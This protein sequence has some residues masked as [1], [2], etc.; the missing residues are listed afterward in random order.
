MQEDILRAVLEVARHEGFE[1]MTMS[2]IAEEAGVAKGTLYLHFQ[3][4]RELVQAAVGSVLDPLVAEVLERTE[5]KI[6]LPEPFLGIART[7]LGYF[8]RERS[9]FQ[10]YSRQRYLAQTYAERLEDTHYQVIHR[11]I[12]ALVR[13]CV[14]DRELHC[15]DPDIAALYWVEG[16]SGM[17]SRRLLGRASVP[18]EVEAERFV[19]LFLYGATGA[20]G[21]GG[22]AEGRKG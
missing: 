2:R 14:A 11:A 10:M 20:G 4:K 3:D 7:V 5:E 13:R 19:R 21:E 22:K 15:V 16:I 18:V 17:I 12:S 6:D 1:G 8:E 9:F